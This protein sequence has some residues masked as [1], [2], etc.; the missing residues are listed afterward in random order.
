MGV[1]G[2]CHL[3]HSYVCPLGYWDDPGE[4]YEGKKEYTERS[5]AT[6]LF[7]LTITVRNDIVNATI[8]NMSS[9]WQSEIY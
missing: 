3:F 4:G 9:K 1:V 2:N 6:S 8:C 5:I 7:L